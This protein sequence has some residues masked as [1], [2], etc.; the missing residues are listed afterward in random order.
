LVGGT[1]VAQ[2]W[3]A[4]VAAV[5]TPYKLLV[6]DCR[7]LVFHTSLCPAYHHSY[8]C[9]SG[10]WQ[11]AAAQQSCHCCPFVQVVG[12]GSIAAAAAAVA[13]AAAAAAAAAVSVSVPG[14]VGGTTATPMLNPPEVAIVALGRVQAL[15]RYVTSHDG[16]A[17][18]L[19]KQHIMSVSWG[20]DHRVVRR[21]RG[22]GVQQLLEAFAGAAKQAADAH[23][24]ITVGVVQL[25]AGDSRLAG[26]A[27]GTL[28]GTSGC[29]P[30]S[31]V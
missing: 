26:T 4:G 11:A 5:P 15:P 28:L 8:V 10:P 13:F 12:V 20:G 14:T 7:K 2:G 24:V 3:P 1:A 6:L 21:R 18:Q 30:V 23:E 29:S 19:V 31:T 27:C 9:C 17:E 16:Q 22:G 25:Q